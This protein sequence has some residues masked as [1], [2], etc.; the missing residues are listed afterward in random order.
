VE[1]LGG[2]NEGDRVII[3]GF[4]DLENGERISVK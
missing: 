3:A 2:L 1:V 4:E